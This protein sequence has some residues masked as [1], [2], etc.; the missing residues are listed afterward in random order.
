MTEKAY[1][2]AN[3]FLD[4]TGKR[5]DGYHLI[6]SVFKTL[7]FLYDTVTLELNG[8]GEITVECAVASGKNN[9]AFRAC[10]CFFKFTGIASGAHIHIEKKIPAQAGLGGGSSDAAAV[11]K[12]LNKAFGSP[13]SE[14]KLHSAALS[15]GADVPFFLYGGTAIVE[16]IGEHIVPVADL[17]EM[18]YTVEMGKKGISTAQAYAQIDRQCGLVHGDIDRFFKEFPY[19]CFNIFEQAAE[20]PEVFAIKKQMLAGGAAAAVMSGSG[21]AVVGIYL[22]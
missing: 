16:G 9:I 3:L 5:P 12:M 7:D 8:S 17:P 2:K 19:A 18:N 11:L 14:Q 22:K 6:K 15:L 21:A 13:L 1:A 10:E 20:L 4:I